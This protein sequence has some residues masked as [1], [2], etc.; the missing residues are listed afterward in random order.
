[1]ALLNEAIELDSN[2]HQAKINKASLLIEVNDIEEAKAIFLQLPANIQ[3]DELVKE[4]QTKIDLIE[5]TGDLPDKQSLLTMI[6]QD[7]SNLRA[8]IDLANLYISEQSYDEALDLLFEVLK[9][10]RDFNDQIA[11]KTM[12]SV[13]T[14]I[15]PQDSRVRAARKTLASL[16]N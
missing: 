1:M 9:K 8:R 2:N 13:F 12:L 3:Q 7:D 15:G 11:R 14:L 10:D 5:R 16:L 6:E 4:L